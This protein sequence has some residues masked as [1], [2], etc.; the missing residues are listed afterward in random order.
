MQHMKARPA[1]ATLG[2]GARD[3]LGHV[4]RLAPFG[5]QMVLSAVTYGAGLGVEQVSHSMCLC[6]ALLWRW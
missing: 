3:L 1:A 5:I 2:G 6:V 4:A